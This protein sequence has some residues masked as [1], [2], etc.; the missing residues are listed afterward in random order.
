MRLP[1]F[2]KAL[3]RLTFRRKA[4]T[5]VERLFGGIP[6]HQFR[7]Y[8]S[9]L[10]AVSK[11]VWA[12][13]KA[14]DICANSVSNTPFVVKRAGG[15]DPVKVPELEQLF[16]APNPFQ[17]WRELEYLSVMHIKATGN[18]FWYKAE[19]N[20]QGDRPRQIFPLNPRRI[21]IVPDE[22]TGDPRGYIYQ[23]TNG[24]QIP[25]DL[26][27]VIHFRRPHPNNDYYGLGDI[28]PGEAIYND[29]INRNTWGEGFWKNGASPSGI[30]ICED[31][32]TDEKEWEQIKLKWKKDYQGMDNTGK[33]AWLSGK[34]RHEQL[35]LNAAEMQNIEQAKW[36]VEQIFL[37]MGVPLS[38]A[39]IRDAA[40]YATADIDNQRFKEYT[41]LPIV[42]LL[43]DT[44]NTDLIHG[45]DPRLTLTFNVTGLI[46]VGKVVQELGPAF[47]RGWITINEARERMGLD[48][49][50]DNPIWNQHFINA[51]LVPIELAGVSAN[52]GATD[53]AAQAM[54]QRFIESKQKGP[55][56]P[57]AIPTGQP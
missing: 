46:N 54:I 29:H 24:L 26:E 53:Q 17:T 19:A 35:G 45:W 11:K 34:W 13:W 47:D 40:N 30:L 15:T 21:K 27:E 51:G 43:Q 14:C 25:F 6:I 37:M 16:S 44:I 33:Q 12:A 8:E 2:T 22:R 20:L 3:Q 57:A 32:I 18:G 36:N 9:Y 50:D 28:E 41:I 1:S 48:R 55:H 52:G 42:L 56:D 10:Q 38:V 7:N 23:G 39:G 49:D 4:V 31:N 5:A